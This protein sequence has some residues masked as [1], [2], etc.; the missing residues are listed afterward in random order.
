[1]FGHEWK[2]ER[3]DGGN[4]GGSAQARQQLASTG[5][6]RPADSSPPTVT[7]PTAYPEISSLYYLIYIFLFHR[8]VYKGIFILNIFYNFYI[9]SQNNGKIFLKMYKF[10]NK[11][12]KQKTLCD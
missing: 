3:R 6:H 10:E 1:M 12:L 5:R 9:K 11:K 4:D 8:Y 2:N 7:R